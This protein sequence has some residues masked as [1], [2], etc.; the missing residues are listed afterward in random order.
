MMSKTEPERSMKM[1]KFYITLAVAALVVAAATL[2]AAA[3]GADDYPKIEIYGGYSHARVESNAGTNTFSF[4]GPA[5][6]I[7][8]CAGLGVAEMSTSV[9]LGASGPFVAPVDGLRFTVRKVLCL[10]GVQVTF[11]SLEKMVVVPPPSAVPRSA[12][13]N[14]LSSPAPTPVR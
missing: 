5:T 11:E 9:A 12:A 13:A 3:K 4:G 14:A 7:E 6:T 10:P 1:K 2:V 8:P